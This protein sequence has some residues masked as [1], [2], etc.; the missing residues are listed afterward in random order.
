MASAD[1]LTLVGVLTISDRAYN[2]VYDDRGGPGV[3]ACVEARFA[4]VR[5]EKLLVP[6]EHER[7]VA[8]IRELAGRCALVITTGG[9]GLTA[10]DV[11]PEA[12]AEA[13]DKLAPGF[14][15]KMRAAS[16]DRVPTA[17]L[18]RATAGVC[19]G[20]FVLNV[21]G[22]IKAIAEC[23]DAVLH[24]LPHAVRLASGG[25]WVLKLRAEYEKGVKCCSTSVPSEGK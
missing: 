8:G 12:T 9:T 5:T 23:I 24:A 15:E 18:S 20:C 6:D 10:R 19:D 25:K 13:C 14:G 7:I 11:T 16:W 4:N 17:I 3:I 1:E 2:G 22:S 21:P